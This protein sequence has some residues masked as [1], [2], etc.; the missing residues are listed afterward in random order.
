MITKLGYSKSESEYEELYQDLLQSGLKMVISYYTTQ[1]GTI[2]AMNGW[3]AS[4]VYASRLE[5]GQII[6]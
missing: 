4:K 1:I 5:K 2:F 3:S 6:D